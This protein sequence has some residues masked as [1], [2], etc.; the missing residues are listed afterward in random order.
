M[1]NEKNGQWFWDRYAGVYDFFMHK[2]KKAYDLLGR[3]I[4]NELDSEWDVLELAIGTGLVTQ[5][6]AQHCRSY[7][8]TDYSEKMLVR[9]K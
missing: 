6:V 7:L 1:K 9:A 5:R 3:K 4:C 8:A 2:D